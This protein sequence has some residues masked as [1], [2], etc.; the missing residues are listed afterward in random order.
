MAYA[1]QRTFFDDTL[2]T[3]TPPQ[4]LP[5]L[6]GTISIDLETKDPLFKTHGVGWFSDQGF[7]TGISVAGPDWEEYFPTR[8]YGGGN[9]PELAVMNWL[10]EELQNPDL[11][12]RAFNWLHDGGWL[13]R[14]GIQARGKIFDSLIAAPLIDENRFSNSL[15]ACARTWLEARKDTRT[16]KEV[17]QLLKIKDIS[18]E[19]DQI[20]APF[21][22]PYAKQD[23]RL[24]WDLGEALEK[25]IIAED[26]GQIFDLE[27]R[28]VPVLLAMRKRGVRVNVERAHE[29]RKLFDR[30]QKTALE[31]I[32]RISGHW[33][34][35]FNARQIGAMLDSLGIKYARTIKS[36]EPSITKDYLARLSH[37]VAKQISLGRKYALAIGTFIDGHVLGHEI[38]GRIHGQFSPLRKDENEGGGGAVTG[39]F[40]SSNPNLQNLPS[41]DEKNALKD[42]IGEAIRGLFEP[43]E[44]E[45]WA[46]IDYSSQEP[47]LSVHFAH[48]CKIPGIEPF[49]QGYRENPKMDF[50]AKGADICGLPR[51]QAK[52][53]T[54]GKMY[55]MGGAKCCHSLDLPTLWKEGRDGRK[56]EVAGP[57]GQAIMDRYDAYMPWVKILSDTCQNR[58]EM[59]G[60]IRTILKRLRHFSPIH[61]QGAFPYKSLNCLIQGS[62]ADMIKKAMVDLW[63]QANAAPMVTVHDELGFSVPNRAVGEYYMEVMTS[64]TPLC[65]PVTADLEMGANWGAAA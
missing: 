15:D 14:Y 45:Q 12:I 13:G 54:L 10:R 30:K 7:I 65:I 2:A 55:G 60:W 40:S 21:I 36:D 23:A 33:I 49:V 5:R 39:R 34:D 19:M 56:F 46:A 62:A 28:L 22:A 52:N 4:E 29:V 11:K 47:R 18:S 27:T 16:I 41:R 57:E 17:G 25:Q 24:H 51:K 31:E 42:E 59:R 37:P 53:L 8:H 63:E 58:A 50:H 48:I 6:H 9:L 3:W 44:G 43:E 20:P 61:P 64:S 26:L 1:I 32:H 38:N 35:V